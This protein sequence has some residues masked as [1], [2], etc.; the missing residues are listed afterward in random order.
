[1]ASSPVTLCHG[2]YRMENLLYGIK[3]EHD[4]I[5]VLDWQGPLRARGMNDVALFTGQSTKTEVRRDHERT[6][7]ERYMAGLAERG[8]AGLEWDAVWEDYRRSML[9]NWVYVTVVAGTLDASN[10]TAFAWMKEM[11]ARQSAVSE[12]LEVFQL[13]DT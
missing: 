10:E 9:Y 2:D 1:M 7:L 13:L 3:P 4:P 5:V 12:D 8:V 11:V 6:L